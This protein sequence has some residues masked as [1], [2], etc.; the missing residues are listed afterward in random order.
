MGEGCAD[1][2]EHVGVIVAILRRRGRDLQQDGVEQRRHV[3]LLR[4]R[5]VGP[6]WFCDGGDAGRPLL[7]RAGIPEAFIV[8]V[9][10]A[11]WGKILELETEWT[12]QQKYI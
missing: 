6:T 12:K 1:F 9:K 7:A 5:G 8:D 10:A 3:R 11:D 2:G 4:A